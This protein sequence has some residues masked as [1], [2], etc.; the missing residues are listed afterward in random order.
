MDTTQQQIVDKYV[1]GKIQRQRDEE[2]E[3]DDDAELLELLEDDGA[4]AKFRDERIR[5]LKQEFERIDAATDGDDDVGSVRD[6]DSEK[7]LM[8]FVTQH[9]TVVVHFYQPQFDKC[10]IMNE[11]LRVCI[12][13]RLA[14][15]TSAHSRKAP[16]HQGCSHPGETGTVPRHQARHKGAP[17]RGDLPQRH[18]VGAARWLRAPRQ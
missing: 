3:S 13:Q 11:K 17:L 15:L 18:G 7:E 6:I 1:D 12:G 10:K 8:A 5:Q 14:L 2:Y 9:E 4:L 16:H